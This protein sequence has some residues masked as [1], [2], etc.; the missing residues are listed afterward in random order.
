MKRAD[1]QIGTHYL[2]ATTRDWEASTTGERVEILDTGD[3]MVSGRWG[4][5]EA[6]DRIMDDGRVFNQVP[7]I[8][9]PEKPHRGGSYMLGRLLNGRREGEYTLVK[10]A[11]VKGEWEAARALQDANY[12]AR[13]AANVE[14]Q[15][16]RN[17]AKSRIATLSAEFEAHYGFKPR[18]TT[19]WSNRLVFE[20]SVDEMSTLLLRTDS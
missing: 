12:E 5:H 13:Q 20:L 18:A 8:Y 16:K 4:R 6:E 7:G 1:V 10:P 17:A 11:E 3:W 9:V 14:M 19:N 2:I 15:A